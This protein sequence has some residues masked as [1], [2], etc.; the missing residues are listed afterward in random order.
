MKFTCKRIRF[1]AFFRKGKP[2]KLGTTGAKVYPFGRS[3]IINT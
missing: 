2:E 3:M 1:I